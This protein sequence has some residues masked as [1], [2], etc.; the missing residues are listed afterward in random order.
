MGR[1]QDKG[2]LDFYLTGVQRDGEEWL[3][4]WAFVRTKMPSAIHRVVTSAC[5]E[6]LTVRAIRK[7]QMPTSDD[8]RADR[9]ASPTRLSNSLC[10][11]M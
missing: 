1:S 10:V 6:S 9:Q 2:T 8:R 7:H 5:L 4:R 11:H 3:V